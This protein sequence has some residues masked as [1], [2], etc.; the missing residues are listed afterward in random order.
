[1]RTLRF[2]LVCLLFAAGTAVAQDWKGKGTLGGTVTDPAG[3]TVGGATVTLILVDAKAGPPETKTNGKGEWKVKNLANGTWLVRVTKE[4]FEPKEAQVEVGGD[5]KD[6]HVSMRLAP[7][8]SADAGAELVAAE[9]K[10]AELIAEKKYAEARAIY[11]DLLK[12]YPKIADIHI[13]LSQTYDGEGQ[14]A[15]AAAELRKFLELNPQRLDIIGFYA[16]ENS[17]AGNADE[18]LR[19]L[20][21]IPPA[22]MKDVTDLQECG[23]HL[24]R[25]KKPSHAVK[26]FDLAIERFPSVPTHY[27][28]RGLS[29]WQIGA[30]D[31]APGTPE[32]RAHF[33]KAKA[34]LNKF[35][36]MAPDAPEAANA[37]KILEYVK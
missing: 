26:F 7:V 25:A 15:Q 28:Y 34:D 3:Q 1:M 33:D 8:G 17:K 6:P 12:K 30:I 20:T 2:L 27:Y 24:L 35:L 13:R 29:E 32:S 37:K 36:G 21:A 9:K 31:A 18:A 22:Q 4:K 11:E 23:F 10:G 14:F 19:V 16:V 5:A